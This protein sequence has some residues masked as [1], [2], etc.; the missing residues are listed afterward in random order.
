MQQEMIANVTEA[1]VEKIQ[2]HLDKQEERLK[3]QVKKL[4][5]DM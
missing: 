3:K 1:V 5:K 4:G 2:D